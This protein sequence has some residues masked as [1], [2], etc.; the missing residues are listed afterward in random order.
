M[1]T[2]PRLTILH[3]KAYMSLQRKPFDQDCSIGTSSSKNVEVTN[4]STILN[5]D[6][7]FRILRRESEKGHYHIDDCKSQLKSLDEISTH[8]ENFQ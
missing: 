4:G 3:S 5:K 8:R 6:N 7:H 1:S 2:T